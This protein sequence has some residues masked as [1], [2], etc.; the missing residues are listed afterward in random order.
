ML[1]T[2]GKP[3]QEELET[4]T[5]LF[6]SIHTILFLS[7]VNNVWR[8]INKAERKKLDMQGKINTFILS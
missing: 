1:L 7:C 6:N 3:V 5:L 8:M 2:T 4:A